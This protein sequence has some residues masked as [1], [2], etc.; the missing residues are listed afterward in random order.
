MVE[1]ILKKDV[2][3]LG[4]AGEIVDVKAGFARNYLVPRG[5]ALEATEANM[6]QL[7]RERSSLEERRT[8][9]ANEAQALSERIQGVSL[10]FAVKAGEE[11]KLFGSVTSGDIAAALGDKGVEIDRQVV[12]LGEPI[13]QL[14]EYDVSIRLHPDIIP[15]VHVTV[16]AEA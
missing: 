1:L 7:T 11:G 16:V 5:M 6:R 4:I 9:A 13:K 12:K 10:E 3:D 8:R 14:G 2:Q 15:V